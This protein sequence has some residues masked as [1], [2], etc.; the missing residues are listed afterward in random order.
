MTDLIEIVALNSIT[1]MRNVI[2]FFYFASCSFSLWQKRKNK[3]NEWKYSQLIILR[4]QMT[5]AIWQESLP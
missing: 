2:F 3:Q 5:P 4:Q 1:I